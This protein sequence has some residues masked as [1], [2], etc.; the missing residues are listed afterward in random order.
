MS[1]VD[2]ILIYRFLRHIP[3]GTKLI[4]VGDPSQLPPIG[5]GLVLH[6]LAAH[7]AVPKTELCVSQRQSASGIPAVAD[8]VRAHR[9]PAFADYRGL[10]AGVSFVRCTDAQ[11]D[12]TV[13]RVY[14]ELLGDASDYAVQVLSIT[15]AGCGGVQNFVHGLPQ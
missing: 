10:G 3:L 12:D 6:V 11:I 13:R 1:T 14:G 2:V 4:L 15:K 7:D 5:P 9:I 8:A